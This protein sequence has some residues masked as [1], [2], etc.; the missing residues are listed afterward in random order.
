M[1]FCGKTAIVTG[2][3]A[4]IGRATALQFAREGANVVIVDMNE[5]TLEKA[6]IEIEASGGKILAVKCDVSDE[7]S[8]REVVEKSIDTFGR[9]DILINNAGIWRR[10]MPFVETDSSMW[11]KYMDVNILGAMYF[12]HAVLPGMIENGYGKIV[13]VASIAGVYG[14]PEMVDYSMTKGALIAFS[15]ALA[16]EVVKQGVYVNCVSPGMVNLSESEQLT[17]KAYAG[18]YGNLEEYSGVICFLAS[19]EATYVCGQNLQIDGC[20]KII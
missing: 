19:D 16:K 9:V 13:N 12:S 20:R 17:D 11:K 15:K 1:R 14:N 18:R 3:G 2:A 5:E 8:V 10:M 7:Q 6:K 4:G